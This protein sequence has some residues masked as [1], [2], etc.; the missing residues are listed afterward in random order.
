[1]DK[2]QISI[3]T[4]TAVELAQDL[5]GKIWAGFLIDGEMK[6]VENYHEMEEFGADAP[7]FPGHKPLIQCHASEFEELP[8][9]DAVM[10]EIEV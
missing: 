9:A 4:D 7:P 1:M 5:D 8:E 2:K 3:V 10:S 6:W